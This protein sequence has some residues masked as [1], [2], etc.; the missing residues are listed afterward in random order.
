MAR[1]KT[2]RKDEEEEGEE[3]EEEEEEE[4]TS[5][6][7]TCSLLGPSVRAIDLSRIGEM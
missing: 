5:V 4:V 2:T 3:E 6:A 7:Q 1:W